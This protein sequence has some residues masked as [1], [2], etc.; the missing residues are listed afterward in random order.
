MT[1]LEQLLDDLEENAVTRDQAWGKR[2][3]DAEEKYPTIRAAIIA[4]CRGTE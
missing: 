2:R 3:E 1:K 4:L